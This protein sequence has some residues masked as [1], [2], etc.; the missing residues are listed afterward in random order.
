MQ[1]YLKVFICAP[2]N[3]KLTC[4]V[5]V[6]ATVA[7]SFARKC[8]HSN[9]TQISLPLWRHGTNWECFST[10]E[11]FATVIKTNWDMVLQNFSQFNEL[12]PSHQLKGRLLYLSQS[13]RE[14]ALAL[15]STDLRLYRYYEYAYPTRVLVVCFFLCTWI[16]STRAT[17]SLSK[18]WFLEWPCG[19]LNCTRSEQRCQNYV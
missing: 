7:Q 11:C 19:H 10:S 16:L 17:V 13:H 18:W 1:Y 4:S 2:W 8:E 6:D 5:P 3:T 9:R 12:A 15:L 14:R